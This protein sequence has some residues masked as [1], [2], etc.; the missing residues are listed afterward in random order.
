MKIVFDTNVLISAFFWHGSPH[1][2]LK[3]VEEGRLTLCTTPSLLEEVRDVLNRQFFSPFIIKRNTSSEEIIAA[4]FEIV[5]LYPDIK[6]DPIVKNDPDDDKV[7]SCALVSD[8]KYIIT[9]DN[10]LLKLKKWIDISILT[11]QQ[12][13]NHIKTC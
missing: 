3:L 9:G 6:I 4:L 2:L 10:H 12:F 1:K 13:L 11:P 8:A 5:E 7:L